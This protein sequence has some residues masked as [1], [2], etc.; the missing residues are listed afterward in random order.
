[1]PGI[2]R[3]H[4]SLSKKPPQA[5]Q[6]LPIYRRLTYGRVDGALPRHQSCSVRRDPVKWWDGVA[7][8]TSRTTP[9]WLGIVMAPIAGWRYL[10]LFAKEYGRSILR[11]A[12]LTEQTDSPVEL[13]RRGGPR[14]SPSRFNSGDC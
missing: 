9:P 11:L 6:E 2:R 12:G 10:P 13:L 5:S 4:S 1:M 8:V 7:A 3:Q 14:R